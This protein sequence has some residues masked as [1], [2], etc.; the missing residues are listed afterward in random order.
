MS[1]RNRPSNH[2]RNRHPIRTAIRQQKMLPMM[3]A[4]EGR[5]TYTVDEAGCHKCTEAK[6]K[7]AR[8]WSLSPLSPQSNR[9]AL[10]LPTMQ[11]GQRS[12]LTCL[13]SHLDN[14]G[15]AKTTFNLVF[16]LLPSFHPPGHSHSAAN[17]L[18]P[19]PFLPH[20]LLLSCASLAGPQIPLAGMKAVTRFKNNEF[21]QV[22]H[23]PSKKNNCDRLPETAMR[24]GHSLGHP[25]RGSTPRMG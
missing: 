23:A 14:T 4:Q 25:Q 7:A 22:N 15:H 6:H 18:L 19:L 3:S 10:L 11:F 16:C 12:Q 1:T 8:E 24:R 21:D 2:S 9:A 5:T 17:S 20:P 13:P